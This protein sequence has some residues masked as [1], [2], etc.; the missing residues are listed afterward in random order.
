MSA[1]RGATDAFSGVSRHVNNSV[2]QKFSSSYLYLL[3]ST[4]ITELKRWEEKAVITVFMI[5][6][7]TLFSDIAVEKAGSKEY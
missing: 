5:T 1:T 3:S 6:N 2:S 7:L 4:C